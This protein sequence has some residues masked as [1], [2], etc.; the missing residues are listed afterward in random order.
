MKKIIKTMTSLHFA[1]E[2]GSKQITEWLISIGQNI[3]ATDHCDRTPLD[4]AIED[5]CC[6]G[7]IKA[8]KNETADLLRKHGG[9]TGEEMKAA[10]N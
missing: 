9:K 6:I 5:Q 2:A 4:L 3:N 10:D 8:A 7:P 1:A